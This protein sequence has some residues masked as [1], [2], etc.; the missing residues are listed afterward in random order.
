MKYLKRPKYLLMS[1]CICALIA[2]T[3]DNEPEGT[4]IGEVPESR[5]DVQEL[6]KAKSVQPVVF[7]DS[8]TFDN[9]RKF[10]E[11]WEMFYPWGTDHNGSARM[12]EDQVTLDGN[13]ELLIEANRIY[14]DE[15]DSS[16]DPWLKIKYH[17]GAIHF[18]E[19]IVVSDSLPSWEISGDFQVPTTRG[20]WPAFWITGAWSWPPEIDIMEFKGNNTN[21]QNTVTGPDWQN[22]SWQ[23][24]KTTVS[25]AGNWHNYKV[26]INKTSQTDVE[27]KLYIDGDQ[28]GTHTA[29]FVGK[30]FWLIINMQMEGSSGAPGPEYAEY[31]ARNIYVAATP[32]EAP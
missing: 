23:T 9:T 7:L 26:I 30:P 21:W 1:C 4:G 20:S 10:E 14:E 18:K 15:G 22:T 27:I 12:Y 8:T 31:R 19:H 11:H 2:C 13:G 24:T 5:A 25:D 17:S 29:D 16:A 32:A 6:K 28:T 3:D